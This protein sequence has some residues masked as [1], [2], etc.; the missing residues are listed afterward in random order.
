MLGCENTVIEGVD[1]PK[2]DTGDGAGPQL[3]VTVH[4]RPCKRLGPGAAQR[5]P[6]CRG[7]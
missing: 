4:V 5:F 6:P 7:R 1:W 2:E 3:L